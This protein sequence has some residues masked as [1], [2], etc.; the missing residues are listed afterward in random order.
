[1]EERFKGHWFERY[2]R[3]D[4]LHKFLRTRNLSDFVVFPLEQLKG[5][6]HFG[7]VQ[8][9]KTDFFRMAQPR[10]FYWIEHT[11]GL[12]QHS[13]HSPFVHGGLF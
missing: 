12:Q 4:K 6:R 10:E 1:M 5:V 2:T 3:N 11:L 7:T 13:I 8:S 9:Y